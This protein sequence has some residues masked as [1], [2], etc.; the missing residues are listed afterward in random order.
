[1]RYLYITFAFCLP[2]FCTK[3]SC[4]NPA[5]N[6]KTLVTL[7]KV[8]ASVMMEITML[9]ATMMKETVVDPMW[10]KHS[11][12]CVPVLMGLVALRRNTKQME[13]VMMEIITLGVTL[14]EETAVYA[15]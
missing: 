7:T 14:M 15:R 3:I 9:N 11:A 12:Q 1:M 5:E 13:Y 8:M 2:Y 6:L 4:G 10:T